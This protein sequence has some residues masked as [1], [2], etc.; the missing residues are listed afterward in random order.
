M[1][2][3]SINLNDEIEK[4]LEFRQS[5]LALFDARKDTVI[6]LIDSLSSNRYAQQAVQLSE[7][8]LFSRNY[9][10]LYKAINHSFKQ[11]KTLK[12]TQK[13][14]QQQLIYS[15]LNESNNLPFHLLG[16]DATSLS[17]IYADT[18]SD[19][20]FVYKPSTIKG[21]KPITIG[22]KYSVL[23]SLIND[24]STDNNW[25]IPLD[26]ERIDTQSTDSQIGSKQI[27]TLFDN[28]PEFILD[29]LVVLVVD[30]LYSNQHFL[31]ANQD[32][33]NLVTIARVRSNR[34]FYQ[35]PNIDN[36][37]QPRR[38]HPTWYGDKFSLA[39]KSTWHEV[40]EEFSQQITNK[41]GQ[42]ISLK[43]KCWNN[44]IM[45]GDKTNK[46]YR[47]PFRLLQITLT[48]EQ[49]NLK[50]KP[51]WLIAMGKR[52]NEVTIG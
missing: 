37:N 14:K 46:M 42:I 2:P 10:S 32:Y 40:D 19:R 44:M 41:K 11:N 52:R 33:D 1:H 17:R 13:S 31:S 29:K 26:S 18:L 28:C 24:S 4:W 9:N 38:G 5:L 50:L 21:N 15:T 35:M 12:K 34:V 16:L 39:D 47:H 7:N 23:S 45:K 3:D 25:A 20:S 51:M 6:D 43:I 48:D 22:H 36:N 8:E 49:G 27:Q 30:S